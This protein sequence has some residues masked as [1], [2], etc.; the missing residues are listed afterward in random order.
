MGSGRRAR[1]GGRGRERAWWLLAAAVLFAVLWAVA[2]AL[3]WS[4]WALAVLGGLAAAAALVVP[5]LR[6]RFKQDDTRA[7][8]VERAVTVPGGP[9]RLPLMREAGLAQLRVHTAQVQ[10]P[11]VQ[12]DAEQTV[13]ET[14]GPGRAVL[15]VGHS[16]AGKTRLAAQVVHQRFPDAP[17]LVPESGQALRDLVDEGLDPGG[18][19]VWLDDLERFLG[20]DGLTLGLLARLTSAPL[21]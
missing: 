3:K 16:M 10:V 1:F 8:L 15:L 13:A 20:P 14:L 2:Q 5:E 17:L 21:L 11:Y 4:G 18:V 9:A 6:A 12:R 7:A 19:V